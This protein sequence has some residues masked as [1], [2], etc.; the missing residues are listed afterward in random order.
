MQNFIYAFVILLITNQCVAAEDDAREGTRFQRTCRALSRLFT[1]CAARPHPASVVEEKF[2][3]ITAAQVG[4][5]TVVEEKVT[6]IAAAQVGLGTVV[7][8]KFTPITAAQVV[9]DLEGKSAFEQAKRWIHEWRIC[10]TVKLGTKPPKEYEDMWKRFDLEDAA[11]EN[12][13]KL[14]DALTK[15]EAREIYMDALIDCHMALVFYKLHSKI[16]IPS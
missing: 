13:N 7:E 12:L 9:R 6:P 5:G 14:A 16:T 15:E 4:L 10:R 3:P 2:T 1:Q 11:V 8:E